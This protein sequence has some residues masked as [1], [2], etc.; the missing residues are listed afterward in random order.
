VPRG[1]GYFAGLKSLRGFDANYLPSCYYYPYIERMLNPE[2]WK[3][4]LSHKGMVEIAYGIGIKHPNTVLRSYGGVYLDSDFK[5][6]LLSEAI[7]KVKNVGCAL[8]YKPA[9]ESNQGHGIKLYN[10]NEINTLCDKIK[11]S[12]IL[13]AGDFVLQELLTQSKDTAIFN[14]SSLNCMRITTLNLNGEVSV[15]TR[16]IKCGPKDS[17]VDNIGSGKR[18]VIVGIDNSGCLD[19]IGF[20]GNG[21]TVTSHNNVV[22]S[23]QKINAFQKVL[24]AA[25]LLHKYVPTCKV[26]GWDIALDANDEPILIEGNVVY[27]GLSFEQMCSGPA[28]GTRTDEV[29]DYLKKL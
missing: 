2:R 18:G 15:C 25:V 26:I 8:L 7:A 21:E 6:L 12:E 22:F 27:P 20:Y 1:Y 23:G 19:N 16:A 24:D 10:A 9:T 17:V 14:N 4:I 29:I 11:S 13:S 3:T 28:F 5:P